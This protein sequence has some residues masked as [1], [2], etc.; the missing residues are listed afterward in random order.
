M[1]K[2]EGWMDKPGVREKIWREMS[3]ARFWLSAA[4]T[5]WNERISWRNGRMVVG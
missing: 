1:E 4:E 5:D 2:E 3:E